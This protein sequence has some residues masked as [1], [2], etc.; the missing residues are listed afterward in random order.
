MVIT[1]GKVSKAGPMEAGF[2]APLI[3]EF[4]VSLK[5]LAYSDL[6]I[7]GL[8]RFCAALRGVGV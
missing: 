4:A 8:F 6:T 3:A 7:A 2:L 1:R 5:A